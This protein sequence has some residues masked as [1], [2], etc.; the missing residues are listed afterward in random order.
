[1]VRLPGPGRAVPV[2]GL[3]VK[4]ADGRGAL[5]CAVVPRDTWSSPDLGLNR[6]ISWDAPLQRGCCPATAKMVKV[7]HLIH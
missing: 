3:G 4:G 7:D 2:V 5:C 1:M 6:G